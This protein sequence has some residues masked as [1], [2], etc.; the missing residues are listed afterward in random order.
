MLQVN[1]FGIFDEE[2]CEMHVFEDFF[3]ELGET[4]CLRQFA[5]SVQG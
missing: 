1:V 3:N 5:A 2:G 4:L